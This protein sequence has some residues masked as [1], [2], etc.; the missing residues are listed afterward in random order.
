M[1]GGG[2][3]S[4]RDGERLTDPSLARGLL[5]SFDLSLCNVSSSV[6]AL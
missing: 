4:G 2:I 3:S 1:E 6:R 5:A